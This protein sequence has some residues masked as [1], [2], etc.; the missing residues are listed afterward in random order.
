MLGFL[1]SITLS[2]AGRAYVGVPSRAGERT[3]AN[4]HS[5][6]A[7]SHLSLE[8]QHAIFPMNGAGPE[9]GAAH[10]ER[11]VGRVYDYI[12]LAHLL[13]LASREAEGP[14]GC[15]QY[16]LGR[17][18]VRIEDKAIDHDVCILTEREQAIVVK[19]DLQ[20]RVSSRAKPVAHM[21]WRAND[22]GR[23]PNLCR[24]CDL[25]DNAYSGFSASTKG[26]TE[27]KE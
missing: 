13:D 23:G 22:G 11:S 14:L 27:D 24:G 26:R 17:A 7:H 18:F 19:G 8:Q 3:G 15:V 21:H 12:L 5:P 6:L 2:G 1:P 10:G 4:S 25:A 9:V 20:P 16:D